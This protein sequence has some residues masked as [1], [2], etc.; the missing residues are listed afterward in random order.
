[1]YEPHIKK[2]GVWTIYK[3]RDGLFV[4]PDEWNILIFKN[5]KKL[6]KLVNDYIENLGI[7]KLFYSFVNL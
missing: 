6:Y 2:R 4:S 5:W 3:K 1:M 7:K